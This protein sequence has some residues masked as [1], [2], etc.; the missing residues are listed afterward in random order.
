MSEE[1]KRLPLEEP[2]QAEELPW[3]YRETEQ[4]WNDPGA[5]QNGEQW[6]TGERCIEPGCANPAGTAWSRLWC[7]SCNGERMERLSERFEGA[8]R[9][10]AAID[11]AAALAAGGAE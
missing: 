8:R 9:N 10:L 7:Q 2:G 1:Q 11:G 3:S 5:P 6:H 4:P